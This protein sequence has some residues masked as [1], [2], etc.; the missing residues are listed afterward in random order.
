MTESKTNHER[1]V[2]A[3]LDRSLAG[4][5]GFQNHDERSVVKF[6]NVRLQEI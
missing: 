5:M 2:D 1:I 4:H 6:K 3:K